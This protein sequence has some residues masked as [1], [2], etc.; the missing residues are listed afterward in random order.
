MNKNFPAQSNLQTD[1]LPHFR[2]QRN[3]QT[4]FETKSLNQKFSAQRNLRTDFE[5][6]PLNQRHS[7]EDLKLSLTKSLNDSHFPEDFKLSLTKSLNDRHSP[8]D[9]ESLSTKSLNDTHSPEDFESLSIKSLNDSHF[10]EDFESLSI[11]S[12]N[13]RHSPEDFE[14]LS[15]KSLND[16]HFPEDFES[17]STKS[18]IENKTISKESS[19]NVDKNESP[20]AL[21]TKAKA[22]NPPMKRSK[23]K[24]KS[25]IENKTISK[26]DNPS[27]DKNEIKEYLESRKDFKVTI[28]GNTNKLDEKT[29]T[30]FQFSDK[31]D[32]TMCDSNNCEDSKLENNDLA[33]EL[34]NSDIKF[35]SSMIVFED[36]ITDSII[37]EDNVFKNSGAA[38]ESENPNVEHKD[39]E[40]VGTMKA[41]LQWCTRNFKKLITGYNDNSQQKQELEIKF[42]DNKDSDDNENTSYQSNDLN[43]N[44]IKTE[45][46]IPENFQNDVLIV[47]DSNIGHSTFNAGVDFKGEIYEYEC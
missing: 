18:D 33:T 38:L 6:T 21:N 16:S 5:T 2:A 13:D 35:S 1:F 37:H 32:G 26:G 44:C 15:I 7:Q 39:S 31:K 45:L 11:K 29:E 20:K 25:D 4:D 36:H 46:E 22:K 41:I 17:L 30:T 12:L 43:D 23:T 40:T 27:K 42:F 14:S 34:E 19:S 8:E 3:L 9:F 10:P 28:Q 47:E 24:N